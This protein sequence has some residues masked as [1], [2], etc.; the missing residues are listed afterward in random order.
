[1]CNVYPN[2]DRLSLIFVMLKKFSGELDDFERRRPAAISR[3]STGYSTTEKC[4][5][6]VRFW[7]R[8]DFGGLSII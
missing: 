1:M 5:S 3:A 2:E 7:G 8:A 4:T 6:K